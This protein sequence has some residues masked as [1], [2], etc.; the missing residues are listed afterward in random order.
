MIRPEDVEEGQAAWGRGVV[1]IGS[2]S[3]WEEAH[4][5]AT[6]I[7]TSMYATKNS[8]LLFCPTKASVVPFRSTLLDAVS[9]FV[10]RDDRHP[11]DQGFALEPWVDVRFDNAGIVC[12]GD[13]GLSM[14]T[15]FFK[16]ADGTELRAEYSMV[17]VRDE[18][19]GVRLQLH[20]SSLPYQ[21]D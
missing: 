2:S 16:R 9:Y 6:E 20:H 10:G 4:K 19:G 18:E 17:F 8:D 7:V 13:V 11:E 5:R 1:H 3:S 21:R 14:G 15:Y 12:N